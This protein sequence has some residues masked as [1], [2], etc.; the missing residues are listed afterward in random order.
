M[1][2]LI[3][4]LQFD[5]RRLVLRNTSF[6]LFT[7]LMPVGFYLLFTKVLIT[8]TLGEKAQ[9]AV[10]YL[11]NMIVYSGLLNALFGLAT[12]LLHDRE[13]GLV[14]WLQLTPNGI[15]SYYVSVGLVTFAMNLIAVL[16]L[17]G[18]V[19]AVNHVQLT[20]GQGLGLT[21]GA[22]IGQLPLLSLGVLLSF[23]DRA[24][25][26]SALAN[27]IV[28][29]LAIISGLWWPLG[30][31]PQWVQVIGKVTP[32]YQLNQLLG[33]LMLHGKLNLSSLT[34][35]MLWT[36]GLIIVV[37]SLARYRLKRGGGVVQS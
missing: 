15:C 16:V 20:L 28:F 9:F 4:Q 1:K 34:G 22:L 37:A 6:Q 24:E 25:T 2:I 13:R 35:L 3:A 23:I 29:P 14:R 26:L 17:S 33:A 18:V 7:V 12:L 5:F 19:V 8:G 32:T 31:L 36:L 27:L 21:G 11:G 30:V 10:G